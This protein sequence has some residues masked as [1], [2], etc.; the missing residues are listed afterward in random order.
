VGDVD[1]ID[2]GVEEG[3]VDDGIDEGREDDGIDEGIENEGYFDGF[4]VG[5]TVGLTDGTRVC[6]Q[7]PIIVFFT[8]SNKALLNVSLK[9]EQL[10]VSIENSNAIQW[11][12]LMHPSSQ[13]GNVASI[14]LNGISVKSRLCSLVQDSKQWSRSQMHPLST[15][16]NLL[17]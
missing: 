5:I 11:K 13:F 10:L 15:Q 12:L 6:P 9:N 17:V 14:T 16:V 8:S 2:E 7:W 3:T 1:G 4:I